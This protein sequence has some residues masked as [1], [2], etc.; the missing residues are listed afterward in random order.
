MEKA[1]IQQCHNISDIFID[2]L[3]YHRKCYQKFTYSKTLI[4]RK[5][6]EELAT[7]TVPKRGRLTSESKDVVTKRQLFL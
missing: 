5:R 3:V 6:P 1:H 4:W 2:E 7:P